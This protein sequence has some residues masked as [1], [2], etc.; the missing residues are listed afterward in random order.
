MVPNLWKDRLIQRAG[1]LIY[2]A[3]PRLPS[4]WEGLLV[5]NTH[6]I[7]K[8]LDISTRRSRKT[9]PEIQEAYVVNIDAAQAAELSLLVD[10]EARWENLRRS[11]LQPQ[12]RD[13]S[14]HD[15]QGKQKAY[16]S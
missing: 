4:S 14:T 13:S 12:E 15:W 11:P 2:P 6:A 9:M 10:L 16:E 5:D 7:R 1:R 8:P 3:I